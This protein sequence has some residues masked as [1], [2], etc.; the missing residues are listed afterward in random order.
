MAER[1]SSSPPPLSVIIRRRM[2]G[3]IGDFFAFDDLPTI[4]HWRDSGTFGDDVVSF[5]A[6]IEDG[7]DGG[8]QVSL[9]ETGC[10]VDGDTAADCPR[11]CSDASTMFGDVETFYNCAVLAAI[12]HWTGEV[13]RYTVTDEAERNASVVMGGGGVDLA[14]FDQRTV[15]ES[16]VAC[17]QD[18]CANDELGSPCDASVTGSAVNAS[19]PELVFD[20]LSGFCPALEA[21][22]ND[23]I[24]GPGV[25]VSYVMQVCFAITL[26]LFVKMFN[27]YVRATQGNDDQR[28]RRRRRRESSGGKNRLNRIRTMMTWSDSSALSRTSVAVATTLVEFQ[29][30]QCWFVFALQ[31]A[32][33]LA[34]VV[35]SQEGSFWD[36]IVVNAAIAFHVSQNGILPMFLVQICLHNEGIR[37]TH[38]F[39]GFLMEYVLA[40]IAASQSIYFDDVFRLFRSQTPIDACGGNPSPRT[41]CS[42]VGSVDGLRIGFFPHPMLYKLVFLVLDTIA[43]VVLIVDHVAWEL[44][45]HTRTRHARFGS[46]RVGRGPE[47]RF[48]PHW[49]K[50]RRIF[51]HTLEAMYVIVNVLYA[52]SL[53][54]LM[55]DE[56]FDPSRWSYGQI[57]AMTVWGPVIVKLISLVWSG[58]QKNGL[59]ADSGPPR[60][61]IDNVINL[62]LGS[63]VDDDQDFIKS[64]D[65]ADTPSPMPDSAIE[66]KTA[67]QEGQGE[68]SGSG[69]TRIAEDF[70][71]K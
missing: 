4:L 41:Y 12:V 3:T 1:V 39:L 70:N 24:F 50:F 51:W 6:L 45:K 53:A 17:E 31:I 47:G 16:I 59:E 37:S 52:I 49:V 42:S 43:I 68:A 58:P 61:R 66:K 11:A 63:S 7:V 44:R 48:Q 62:R 57:I 22:I 8:Q 19:N 55:T 27:M 9:I 18:A 34:I 5:G 67:D 33:V 29:E 25:L 71:A 15:L 2:G 14:D 36:E 38:T 46:F 35:R 10:M 65:E 40:I 56:S 13:G 60:L 32:S 21:K 20:S 23:D 30:A 26:Y 28:R 69:A 64:R 54:R